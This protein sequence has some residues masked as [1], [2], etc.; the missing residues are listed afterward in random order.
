MKICFGVYNSGICGLRCKW[1]LKVLEKIVDRDDE[2]DFFVF[3]VNIGD[4]L[5]LEFFI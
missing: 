3:F 1:K 4:F 5:E 2:S